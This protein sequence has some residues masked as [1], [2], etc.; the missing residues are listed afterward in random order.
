MAICTKTYLPWFIISELPGLNPGA[1]KRLL[2]RFPSP[3]KI[4][5]ASRQ[6]LSMVSGLRL[7]TVTA[8]L[9]HKKLESTAYQRLEQISQAGYKV[10]AYTDATY[11]VLLKEIPD[12]PPLLFYEGTMEANAPCISLVGSRNATRYGMDT[13]RYLAARLAQAGF[14][15][16]SGMALGVDTAAHNGALET[17]NGSTLAVLGSGLANIYPRQNKTLYQ[18]IKSKGAVISEFFPEMKPLPVNF[19]RRNRIIAGLSCG[20]VVVEAASKSGSLITARL[21]GEFNREVFAVPGSIR[22]SKSRG[23]P[24]PD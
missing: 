7:E 15:V 6:E 17:D 11:P 2:E 10:V 5:K 3:G 9:D 22:S 8:I 16:V 20:T 23:T 21:A 4:L 13:A 12:P 14:T 18:R 1:I 24:P 19:P